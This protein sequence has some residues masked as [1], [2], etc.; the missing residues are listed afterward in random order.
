MIAVA[1]TRARRGP[2]GKPRQSRP[3]HPIWASPLLCSPNAPAITPAPAGAVVPDTVGGVLARSPV[4]TLIAA[5]LAS[6]SWWILHVPG[7][8]RRG[9]HHRR[10]LRPEPMF[11]HQAR[12][13]GGLGGPLHPA[14]LGRHTSRKFPRREER[15]S[16]R[17][18]RIRKGHEPAE[19]MLVAQFADTFEC[20]E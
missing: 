4:R 10:R 18:Q 7:H 8:R 19:N 11:S 5:L 15:P 1:G 17:R 2:E 3:R 9:L 14:H 6:L 20:E 12:G 13:V 16:G